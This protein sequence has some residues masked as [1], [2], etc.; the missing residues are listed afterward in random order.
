MATAHVVIAGVTSACAISSQPAGTGGLSATFGVSVQHSMSLGPGQYPGTDEWLPSAVHAVT[1]MHSPETPSVLTKHPSPPSV[2]ASG[3][4]ASVLESAPA[5]ASAPASAP[6]AP[7]AC[8]AAP[9]ADAPPSCAASSPV[10][11]SVSRR[12]SSGEALEH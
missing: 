9:S 5:L 10:P 6:V 8:G 11:E 2:S 7:S 4:W 12:R 1:V 3:A